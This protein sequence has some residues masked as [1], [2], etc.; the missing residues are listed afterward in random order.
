MSEDQSR[1]RFLLPT[2]STF[3][4]HARLGV[5]GAGDSRIKLG[6]AADHGAVL[7]VATENR[8][9]NRGTKPVILLK[10]EAITG[11]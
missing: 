7:G 5:D 4:R 6:N 1:R 3:D 8:G 9:T 2:G 11:L 10:S